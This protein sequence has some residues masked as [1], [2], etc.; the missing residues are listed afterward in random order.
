[1]PAGDSVDSLGMEILTRCG[2]LS[3]WSLAG[4]VLLTGCAGRSTPPQT[5]IQAT[6][7]TFRLAGDALARGQLT[8][9]LPLYETLAHATVAAD[10]RRQALLAQ[11]LI[12]LQPDPA[13]HDLDKARAA[14]ATARD[15]YAMSPPAELTAALWLATQVQDLRHAAAAAEGASVDEAERRAAELQALDEEIRGLKRTVRQLRQ[16]LVRRDAALKKAADAVVGTRNP[17]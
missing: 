17:R 15:L 7:R 13:V 12:R 14:L 4:I 3:S 5:S 8:A 11:G 9:A 6:E 16:D 10:L 1:M 2:P